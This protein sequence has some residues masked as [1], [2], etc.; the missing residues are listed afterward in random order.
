[1]DTVDHAAQHANA[2]DAI[3]ALEAKVGADSSAVTTSHDYKLSGVSST[4]KA[5]S[6]AGTETLTNKTLTSPTLTTPVVSSISNTGTLTLPTSTDTLVG[7]D[8][9]DTLTNKSIDGDTNTITDINASTS[10]KTGTAVPV[11]NGGTGQTTQTAGFDALSPTTTKGDIIVDD[12]TNAVRVAVGAD[13]T[14]LTADSAQSSGVA[15]ST[16]ASST[17]VAKDLSSTTVANT[18][19]DTTLHSISIPASTLGTAD[20]VKF[21][22]FV[23]NISGDG[24]GITLRLKYGATTVAS[25][26]LTFSTSMDSGDGFIE[27]FLF[28]NGSTSSQSG[29]ILASFSDGTE[30]RSGVATGTASE[31]STGALNLIVS[32]QHG[33]ASASLTI[34]SELMVV[35]PLT[36]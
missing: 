25:A 21:K 32:A 35:T 12:G 1:M 14:V 19:T 15:W 8:T 7:R 10:L 31:D 29:S 24:D 9:T 17:L 30:A 28:G 5:A 23:S 34:T 36:A 20:G 16:I 2:N 3:E 33:S 26:G 18:T 4:D 6:L 13:N 11:A 27:G 22:I